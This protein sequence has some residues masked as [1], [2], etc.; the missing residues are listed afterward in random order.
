LHF[1]P[2]LIPFVFTLLILVS[3]KFHQIFGD[4]IHQDWYK[5]FGSFFTKL[6]PEFRIN[7]PFWAWGRGTAVGESKFLWAEKLPWPEPS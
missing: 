7:K 2:T 4:G 1:P 6:F 5:W 3:W